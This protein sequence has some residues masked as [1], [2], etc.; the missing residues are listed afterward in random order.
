MKN[1]KGITLIALVIT[2]I[3]LLIL[4]GVSISAVM[5]ENGIATKAKE[6]KE[7]TD[8]ASFLEEV[9]I[10]LADHSFEKVSGNSEVLPDDVIDGFVYADI[11]GNDEIGRYEIFEYKERFVKVY[12]T[13][14]GFVKE[15]VLATE[16]DLLGD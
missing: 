6:A 15:V 2:I 5:W 8:D 7:E 4:A 11:E 12:Y 10:L 9:E 13:D 1:E 3:V 16:A 14:D